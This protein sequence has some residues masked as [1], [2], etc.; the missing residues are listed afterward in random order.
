MLKFRK[1]LYAILALVAGT[2]MVSSGLDFPAAKAGNLVLQGGPRVFDGSGPPPTGDWADVFVSDVANIGPPLAVNGQRVG[3]EVGGSFATLSQQ[4]TTANGATMDIVAGGSFDGAENAVRLFPP[5]TCVGWPTSNDPGPCDDEHNAEYAAWL[6]NLDLWNNASTNIA[7]MNVRILV[8]YG[9]RYFDLAPN[10]KSWGL[11]ATSALTPGGGAVNNRSGYFDNRDAGW[12]SFKF[13]L[14]TAGTA[15]VYCNPYDPDSFHI[16]SCPDANKLYSIGSSANHAA[17]PPRTGGEWICIE[18]V[19]DTRQN[20]GNANGLM[21]VVVW[22]R[23]GV[24]S[25]RT[26]SGPLSHNF[27]W[28][29]AM[30]YINGFE[31]LGFYFNAAGT[32]NANNFVMWSH[33]TFAANMANTNALI[34][35]PPG[36]LQ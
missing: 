19:F 15:G 24:V 22:T 28:D 14:V 8:Y 34:G 20:R 12:S 1:A 3:I 23:D 4:L 16:D 5:T 35:P 13:P 11:T 25:G 2:Y 27:L 17:S 10:A 18:Q 7:Q 31:G 6:R 36:F 29:F 21:K 9:T 30:Q 32:A 26:I 33:V